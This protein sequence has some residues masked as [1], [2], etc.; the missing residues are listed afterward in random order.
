MIAVKNEF[1]AI[2][3]DS[4][5]VRRSMLAIVTIERGAQQLKLLRLVAPR[6]F[7]FGKALSAARRRESPDEA[8]ATNAATG[9]Q[10]SAAAAAASVAPSAAMRANNWRNDSHKSPKHSLRNRCNGLPNWRATRGWRRDA[11]RARHDEPDANDAPHT[12]ARAVVPALRRPRSSIEATNQQRQQWR[13]LRLRRATPANIDRC[14]RNGAS[15][16]DAA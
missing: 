16:S 6:L 10:A 15:D 8:N 4:S 13:H 1:S 5:R 7:D 12:N 11:S 3:R 9:S 2:G 14:A